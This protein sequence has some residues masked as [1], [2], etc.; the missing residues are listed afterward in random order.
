MKTTETRTKNRWRQAVAVFAFLVFSTGAYAQVT[1][2]S[3]KKPEAFSVLEIISNQQAGMRMP[4]LTTKERNDM[5]ATFGTQKEVL[6][7]GLTIFNTTT[8]CLEF[9][10]GA[11]WISSCEGEMPPYIPVTPSANASV[12]ACAVT[13]NV[14]SVLA[15]TGFYMFTYQTMNLYANSTGDTPTSYQ[16]V[17]DGKL[18]KGANS[19]TFAYTPPADIALEAD[20]PDDLALSNYKKT[21]TITCQM[22]V[23]GNDIEPVDKFDILVV[24]ATKGTLSPIYVWGWKDGVAGDPATD[25]VKV[26][27]AHVNL[28]AEN[29]TDPC[30]CLGDLYQW[31]REKDGNGTTT[32][33][34]RRKLTGTDVWPNG[35]GTSDATITT[36]AQAAELDA[37]TGQVLS[38]VTDKYGKYIK[39][40][41][42]SPAYYDWRN[43]RKH[44]LW[45][46]GSQDYNPTWA[47]P[48]NNPCPTGWKVPSQKQWS[49]IYQ[50]GT[51]NGAPGASTSGSTWTGLGKFSSGSTSG[52]RV[53]EA[54]YL[55][56]AGLRVNL[57]GSLD[58]VGSI[59]R[60][61][62]STVNT[63][64]S[65]YGLNFDSGNVY[66]GFDSIRGT[67]RSVRCIPE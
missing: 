53:A 35:I 66:S 63:S 62:S 16:W 47:I 38:S 21:V 20:Y 52:Y 18:I 6:A 12:T 15:S 32:G 29:D 67:G 1:M 51:T 14:A 19:A 42:T 26:A 11:K 44:D 37:A 57:T 43:S 41:S 39:S 4:H 22:T 61:W 8:N 36:I 60:Y 46:D 24:K 2:G 45:G 10:N 23:K 56:A 48:S 54:L 13:S 27:F 49:A 5:T 33:H 9:W 58:P 59:G 34:F 7:K 25:Q 28:G 55:P 17:V 64:F 3:N 31:G 65:S 30:N 50:G 40:L